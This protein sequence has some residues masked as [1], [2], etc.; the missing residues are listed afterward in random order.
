MTVAE[1]IDSLKELPQDME[2]MV[3]NPDSE[4]PR[5]ITLVSRGRWTDSDGFDEDDVVD[6]DTEI[7]SGEF[8]QDDENGDIAVL[9]TW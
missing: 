1:L 8:I 3:M 9:V 4:S 5:D 2:I 6:F 7:A